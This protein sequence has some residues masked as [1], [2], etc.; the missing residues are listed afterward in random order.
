MNINAVVRYGGCI[1]IYD[2]SNHGK[3]LFFL[4]VSD[5]EETNPFK[6]LGKCKLNQSEVGWITTFLN[7]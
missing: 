7:L 5:L 3:N 4:A 2:F 1:F 6:L